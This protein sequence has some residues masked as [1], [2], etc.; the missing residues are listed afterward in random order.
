MEKGGGRRWGFR[1]RFWRE[2]IDTQSD[3]DHPDD[4]P[5]HRKREKCG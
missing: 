1:V 4:K 2:V 3:P 5:E